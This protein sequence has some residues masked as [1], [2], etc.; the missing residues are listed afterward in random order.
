MAELYLQCLVAGVVTLPNGS[1]V[2]GLRKY[3]LFKI[4]ILPVSAQLLSVIADIK[5]DS[6]SNIYPTGMTRIADAKAE[7]VRI[8]RS[9]KAAHDRTKAQ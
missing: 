5:G 9:K 6:I 1:K 7:L 2:N 3:E 8:R 4:S